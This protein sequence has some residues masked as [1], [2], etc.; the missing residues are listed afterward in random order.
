MQGSVR[1]NDTPPSASLHSP[2]DR[3]LIARL[4]ANDERALSEL[5]HR[6][7][8]MLVDTV[9]TIVGSRDAAQDVVQD[10]FCWLWNKRSELGIRESLSRYL[11]RAAR[12]R[13]YSVLRHERSQLRIKSEARAAHG[14]HLPSVGNGGE[15]EVETEELQSAISAALETLQSRTRQIFLMHVDH[16]LTYAEIAEALEI[17]IPTVRMQMYRATRQLW[18]RLRERL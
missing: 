17:T 2:D 6:Y 9:A 4:Q 16:G 15:A 18:G 14:G 13:A 3:H 11:F 1:D 10:V 8:A 12:N 7:A 5:I